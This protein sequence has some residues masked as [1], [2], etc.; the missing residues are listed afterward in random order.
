[1][2]I[3]SGP[4]G[5][6]SGVDPRTMIARVGPC[7]PIAISLPKVQE[8]AIVQAGGVPST[9]THGQRPSAWKLS[10]PRRFLRRAEIGGSVSELWEMTGASLAS[11]GILALIGTDF[12]MKCLLVYDGPGGRFSLA[13]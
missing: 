11:G 10:R 2:P 8:D 3:L 9:A 6:S 12:L 13:L 4:G 5:I 1:M 7:I